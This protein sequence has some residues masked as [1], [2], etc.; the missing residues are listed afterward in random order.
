MIAKE[1]VIVNQERINFHHNSEL[2]VKSFA[3]HYHECWKCRCVV[4]HAPE[5]QI[6]SLKDEVLSVIEEASKHETK[7]LKRYIEVR[8]MNVNNES[9]CGIILWVRSARVCKTRAR[10]STHEEMRNMLNV[11][12]T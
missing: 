3:K 6:K 12:L 8:T 2:L 9:A 7:R 11:R 1:W 10:K 4:L 5:V